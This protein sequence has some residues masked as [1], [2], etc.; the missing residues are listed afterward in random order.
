MYVQVLIEVAAGTGFSLIQVGGSRSRG[1]I[2]SKYLQCKLICLIWMVC[3]NPVLVLMCDCIC[4]WLHAVSERRKERGDEDTSDSF[5][6]VMHL[7][8]EREQKR[9]KNAR[10]MILEAPVIQAGRS[11]S[12][13]WLAGPR[14]VDGWKVVA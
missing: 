5:F 7:P 10:A 3:V 1:Y 8:S 11:V 9:Q 6:A 4:M 14:G 12:A 13:E 2:R